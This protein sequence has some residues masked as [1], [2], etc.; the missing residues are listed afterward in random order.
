M[1]SVSLLTVAFTLIASL[2]GTGD[3]PSVANL[4]LGRYTLR[5]FAEEGASILCEETDAG[6]DSRKGG[7]PFD[8]ALSRLLEEAQGR[9]LLEASA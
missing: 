8:G 2:Y 5:A 9:A 6:A 7:A 1:S 4:E 3:Q